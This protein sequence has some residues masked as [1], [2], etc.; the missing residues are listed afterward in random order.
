MRVNDRI[1]ERQ[2]NQTIPDQE[3]C[4]RKRAVIAISIIVVC[5][6]IFNFPKMFEYTYEQDD[7]NISDCVIV[8]ETTLA[9]SDS[10]NNIYLYVD[11]VYV[12]VD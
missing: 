8:N 11:V 6:V 7:P 10:Y 1:K 5:D 12:H 4:T 9:N 2:N 3:L